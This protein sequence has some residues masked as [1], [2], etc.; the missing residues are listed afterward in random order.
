MLIEFPHRELG[1]L[2][3]DFGNLWMESV[4]RRERARLKTLRAARNARNPEPPAAA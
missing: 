4:R 2:N 3:P 1:P